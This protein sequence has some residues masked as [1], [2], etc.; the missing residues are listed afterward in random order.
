MSSYPPPEPGNGGDPGQQPYGNPY[1]QGG[2]DSYG[3]Q[4]YGGGPYSGQPQGGGPQLGG[5]GKRFLARLIDGIIVGVVASLI[6]WAIGWNQFDTDNVGNSWKGGLVMAVLYFVYEFVQLAKGGQTLGKK[7]M[8]IR[9]LNVAD[10]TQITQNTAMIRAAMWSGPALLCGFWYI[11]DGLSPLWD[12][13]WA[14]ALH[15]KAAKTVVVQA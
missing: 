6:G 15:D 7:V 5:M 11:I 8:G 1:P 10:G 12:K 2:G 14:Q 3:G 13:P 4:Q 9:V